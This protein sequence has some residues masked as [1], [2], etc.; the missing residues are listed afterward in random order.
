[1]MNRKQPEAGP[2]KMKSKTKHMLDSSATSCY[3]AFFS[4]FT[5]WDLHQ[6][7]YEQHTGPAGIQNS[8]QSSDFNDGSH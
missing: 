6:S 5:A 7:P 8:M 1:M 2:L 3:A 4:F